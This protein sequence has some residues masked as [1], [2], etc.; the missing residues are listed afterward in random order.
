MKRPPTGDS[1]PPPRE[2]RHAFGEQTFMRIAELREVI[3]YLLQ[4]KKKQEETSRYGWPRARYAGGAK[5]TRCTKPARQLFLALY[6]VK[7]Y[8]RKTRSKA[9]IDR[10]IER[11]W[12]S[13][14]VYKKEEEEEVVQEEK[15]R[16]LEHARKEGICWAYW[17]TFSTIIR[18]TCCFSL[19]FS[20]LF[21]DL[22]FQL[23]FLCFLLL[24]LLLYDDNF[25]AANCIGEKKKF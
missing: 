10:W 21:S 7:I 9:S 23:E 14:A 8:E 19:P 25:W 18:P 13:E 22:L 17:V 11:W 20:A 1:F 5:Y 2:I 24:L 4:K 15:G 6:T 12:G 16:I 3:C